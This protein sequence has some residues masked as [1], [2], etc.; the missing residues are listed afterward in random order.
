M[1]IFL[2]FYLLCHERPIW[3]IEEKKQLSLRSLKKT[4]EIQKFTKNG[5]NQIGP[6][7]PQKNGDV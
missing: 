1:R 2:Y 7:R 5:K 6:Q 4:D 3:L